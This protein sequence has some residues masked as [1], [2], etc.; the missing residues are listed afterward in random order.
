MIRYRKP[1]Q[2]NPIHQENRILLTT[3]EGGQVWIDRVVLELFKAADQRSLNEIIDRS[4]S[5][6]SNE[7]QIRAGLACLA[8]AGLLDRE[9][10]GED[11]PPRTSISRH[12]KENGK[13]VSVIIVSY[14]SLRWLADCIDSLTAQS[15][16]PIE[17]ILLDNASQDGSAEWVEKRIRAHTQSGQ[18]QHLPIHL[19]RQDQTTSLAQAINTGMRAASGCYF[20]LLNPDVR[21]DPEAI[22]Q[23]VKVA[24]ANAN[25]AAVSAKLRLLWTP[26]FLNGVGNLVGALSWGVDIGLGHLD[27][28]QFD[29]WD[30]IPSACFAAALIPAKMIASGGSR[31]SVGPLGEGFAMYYEDSE[32]CYR[33]RLFGFTIHLA[34]KAV[35]YH[36]YSAQNSAKESPPNEFSQKPGITPQKLRRVTSGR[37][38]FI[39]RINGAGFFWRFLF[40]YLIEDMARMLS[41]VLLSRMKIGNR[42]E[43]AS[44]F[45]HGWKDAV[46]SL[47]DMIAARKKIQ[48]RR[49]ISDRTLYRLQNQTTAPF[50]HSGLPVFN[51]DAICSQYLPLIAAGKTRP[52]P[53]FLDENISVNESDPQEQK[54]GYRTSDHLTSVA[55]HTQPFSALIRIYQSEGWV[56][57]LRRLG[58][59]I[60]W[61]LMQP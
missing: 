2:V 35:V 48:A 1:D 59:Q 13:L 8:E 39:T 45:S 47:P 3:K 30:E 10:V 23:M 6:F 31:T 25:C 27:L 52:L 16:S 15:Y 21:V 37:L 43:M 57:L 14:N 28:G 17:I 34:P 22:D 53:E 12:P 19:F 56:A 42:F 26:A 24:K 40:N 44:A 7:T 60:Q 49:T 11:S 9:F 51:W 55:E 50:I 54:S 5:T 4:R 33:A 29:H 32:W 46:E 18:Q 61:R 38:R 41:Y 20:L 36:A 58:R